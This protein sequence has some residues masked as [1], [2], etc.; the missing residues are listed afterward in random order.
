MGEDWE[1]PVACLPSLSAAR[2]GSWRRGSTSR[3]HPLRQT[4]LPRTVTFPEPQAQRRQVPHSQSHR[5]LMRAPVSQPAS[6]DHVLLCARLSW[7]P[8]LDVAGKRVTW[9]TQSS[10]LSKTVCDSR[11][12]NICI[13]LVNCIKCFLIISQ[14]EKKKS[15]LV[16]LGFH[17]VQ[18]NKYSHAG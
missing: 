1:R 9:N 17:S 18:D 10:V 2:G 16:N 11:K 4:L 5:R 12:V 7:W 6:K 3:P 15:L 8:V 14:G 13:I